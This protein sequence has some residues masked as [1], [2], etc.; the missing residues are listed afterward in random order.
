MILLADEGVEAQVVA[1]LRRG[2]H[3]V[4][5]V[6]E[7]APGISDD[8]V[9]ALAGELRAVLVTS[10]KDF[11]ELV[12]RQRRAVAG[13]VLV[14]LAGLAADEKAALV[15]AAVGKHQDELGGSFAVITPRAVRLRRLG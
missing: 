5:F 15:A 9:L 3:D 6:A 4:T 13:V 10:D 7:L 11:G 8:G 2:G 14:R 1:A 12:V